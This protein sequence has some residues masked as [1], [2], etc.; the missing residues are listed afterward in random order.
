MSANPE[1]FTKDYE[2]AAGWKK[3][4]WEVVKLPLA[5]VS[6]WDTLSS[7]NIVMYGQKNNQK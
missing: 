4:T 6:F 1:A 7:P 5:L 3:Q 2:D